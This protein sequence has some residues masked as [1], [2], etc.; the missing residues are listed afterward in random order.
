[1]AISTPFSCSREAVYFWDTCLLF[2]ALASPG[3]LDNLRRQTWGYLEGQPGRAQATPT[4]TYLPLL[5][6]LSMQARM[7]WL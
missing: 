4:V 3:F 7:Y 2:L 5:A 6:R 1:M